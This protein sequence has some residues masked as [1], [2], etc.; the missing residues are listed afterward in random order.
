MWAIARTH[1]PHLECLLRLMYGASAPIFVPT[2]STPATISNEIGSRQGC[3]WGSFLYCLALQPVLNQLQQEFPSCFI[4]AYCDDVQIVGPPA[5]AA[6]ALERYGVLLH[7][8]LQQELRPDKTTVFAPSYSIATLRAAPL[9]S[10][11]DHP[12]RKNPL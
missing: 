8:I 7:D 5:D 12:R 2:D 3:S 10:P 6:R 1:F 4:V 9:F 11:F